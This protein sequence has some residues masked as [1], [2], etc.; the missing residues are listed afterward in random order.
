[1]YHFMITFL[2]IFI[3]FSVFY[4]GIMVM[5]GKLIDKKLKEKCFVCEMIDKKIAEKGQPYKEI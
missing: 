2:F 3:A 5:V 4:Y 1:M